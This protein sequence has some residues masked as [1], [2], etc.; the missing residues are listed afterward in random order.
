M[1][2]NRTLKLSK[3]NSLCVLA[4]VVLTLLAVCFGALLL[5]PESGRKVHAETTLDVQV[6][7]LYNLNTEIEFPSEAK[8]EVGENKYDAVEGVCIY[9]DGA[10][11]SVGKPFALNQLGVYT[12]RYYYE[13]EGNR[14]YA[15][16]TFT[17]TQYNLSASSPNT[18]FESKTLAKEVNSPFASVTEGLNVKMSAGDTVSYNKYITLED[19]MNELATFTPITA[20]D[21]NRVWVSF[22]LTDCYDEDNYVD[23]RIDVQQLDAGRFMALGQ[24]S[25]NGNKLYG[26]AG[27]P[28]A[29]A[30]KVV[31]GEKTYYAY[32]ST[33][34]IRYDAPYVQVIYD[35]KTKCAY[36]KS[37][38][39]TGLINDFTA[40]DLYGSDIFQGFTSNEVKLT[41]SASNFAAE[42]YEV[43]F[44]SI[45]KDKGADLAYQL[46]K[47]EDAPKI[48][49]EY[50]PTHKN[51]V[52]STKGKKIKVFDAEAVDLS[53]ATLT[54]AVYYNY[55]KENQIRVT[56]QDGFFVTKYL[57]EYT[58]LYTATD[59]FGNI[60]TEEVKVV[61]IPTEDNEIIS[62]EVPNMPTGIT[63]GQNVQLP[64]LSEINITTLNKNP[65][66][67]VK[68]VYEK[69]NVEVVL[70]EGM[71]FVPLYAGDW[72]IV[73]TVSDSVTSVER[74]R[75]LSVATTDSVVTE[76]EP[77][78][79]KTFIKNAEYS[80]DEFLGY[81][82]DGDNRS[83]IALATSVR[84]DE[85][86]NYVA[87]TDNVVK[88]TGS[89]SVSF[90]YA[91]EGSAVQTTKEYPIVDVGF[92]IMGGW[93]VDKYFTG[94]FEAT[95]NSGGTDFKSKVQNGEN[96]LEFI[97][98]ISFSEFALSFLPTPEQ[99]N[100]S[101][102]RVTLTDYYDPFNRVEVNV[103]FV[104]DKTHFIMGDKTISVDINKETAEEIIVFYDA[105]KK[106]FGLS[107][108]LIPFESTFKTDKCYLTVT[109]TDIEGESGIILKRINNQPIARFRN[110]TNAPQI[111]AEQDIPVQNFGDK[112]VIEIPTATDVLSPVLYSSI[113]VEMGAPDGS[114]V[115]TVDGITLSTGTSALREYEVELNA[116][117]NY[118]VLYTCLDQNGKE[119]RYIVNYSV[120]DLVAPEVSFVANIRNGDV[121]IGSLGVAHTFAEVVASDNLD[122]EVTVR[123]Y[124]IDSLNETKRITDDS[125]VPIVKGLHK[126]MLRAT[127]VS[128][129]S[130]Y[131]YY[132]LDV[133]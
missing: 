50:T 132:Y 18:V 27:S 13:K 25:F 110:D 118:Y 123:A 114:F 40:F 38:T 10:V 111:I 89:K 95:V 32:W 127:D 51:V 58:V 115:K 107:N 82:F 71:Q 34:Y 36:I 72:E 42:Q 67:Q 2:V 53:G 77:I 4:L 19:G 31:I 104:K 55:G 84:F 73:Y 129:N 101:G 41:V 92:G 87:L 63:V 21:A 105:T 80:L 47:E 112:I 22:R 56:A 88:I 96:S 49:V 59:I 35:A 117:G 90:Q 26:Y 78:M 122:A 61:C 11:Y 8:I 65:V 103:K 1:R 79:P 99:M 85:T 15:E 57:G 23:I 66:C 68:A 98:E 81:A 91:Y 33:S 100:Y 86:G 83:E 128:G 119:A 125:Y 124:L 7:Q 43:E 133:Q 93:Q 106:V 76:G 5:S 74:R 121:L 9:P 108:A 48:N 37:N 46:Y 113:K 94:D 24:A 17:V 54:T 131:V 116:Y 44:S 3:K 126:I 120:L 109:L 28:R 62:V 12:L 45:W 60:G 29:G 64:L 52:Y 6:E 70:N 30:P 130:S 20:P 39:S 97:K 75:T 102:V 14:A 16:K 69:E